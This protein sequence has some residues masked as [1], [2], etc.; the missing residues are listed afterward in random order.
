VGTIAGD[1]RLSACATDSHLSG[2]TIHLTFM[3]ANSAVFKE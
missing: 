1:E 3:R 2:C